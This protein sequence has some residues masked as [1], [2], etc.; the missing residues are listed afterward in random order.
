[1]AKG[2]ELVDQNECPHNTKLLGFVVASIV[3]IYLL[4]MNRSGNKLNHLSFLLQLA[5]TFVGGGNCE[6][7]G[8]NSQL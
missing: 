3:W 5:V 6:Y 2:P 4:N 7:P 1:M 8:K